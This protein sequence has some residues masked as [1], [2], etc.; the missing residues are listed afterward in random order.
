MLINDP[1]AFDPRAG[2]WVEGVVTHVN[3]LSIA[4]ELDEGA[5]GRTTHFSGLPDK[6]YR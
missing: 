6:G 4:E 2:G 3:L 5:K 1:L